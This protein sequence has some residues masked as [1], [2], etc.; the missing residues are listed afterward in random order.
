L[1]SAKQF[2]AWARY[3]SSCMF[4]WLAHNRT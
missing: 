2:P 1:A 4:D 3:L